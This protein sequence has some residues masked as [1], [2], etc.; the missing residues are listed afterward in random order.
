[1]RMHTEHRGAL[2]RLTR[3]RWRWADRI[4]CAA[5]ATLL[6][7]RLRWEEDAHANMLDALEALPDEISCQRRRLEAMRVD[8]IMLQ[9]AARGDA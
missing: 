8:L 4:V 3:L 9:A 2:H 6:R 7:M 1:M 5:R